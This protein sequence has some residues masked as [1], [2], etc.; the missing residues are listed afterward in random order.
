MRALALLDP[1][2]IDTLGGLLDDDA[3]IVRHNADF[4]LFSLARDFKPALLAK[5]AEWLEAQSP[6]TRTRAL[7]LFA[8]ID[9][10]NTFPKAVAALSDP[11]ST[12]RFLAKTMVLDHYYKDAPGAEP[13]VKEYLAREKD[14]DVLA[15]YAKLA[16]SRQKTAAP[17]GRRR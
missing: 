9:P 16:A 1:R 12:V 8:D 5:K 14:P 11:S 10:E 7:N 4:A 2:W 15:F 6:F 13:A 17:V 3:E